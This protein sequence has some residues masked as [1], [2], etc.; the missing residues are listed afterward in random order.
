MNCDNCLTLLGGF[1][2]LCNFYVCTHVNFT[3]VNAIGAM[4]GRSHVNVKVGPRSTFTFA[5][6]LSC[7]ASS[8]LMHVI[9]ACT[10]VIITQQWKST[11]KP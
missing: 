7:M 10:Q 8:L 9:H 5:G 2:P 6:G 1:P 11:L 4:N 3:R